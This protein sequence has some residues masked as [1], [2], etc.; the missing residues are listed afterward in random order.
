MAAL[1]A[2]VGETTHFLGVKTG[3]GD[4]VAL[5]VVMEVGVG[6]IV[7]AT[8]MGVDVVMEDSMAEGI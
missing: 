5:V 6:M 1:V 3:E 2:A 8:W 4:S 7:I